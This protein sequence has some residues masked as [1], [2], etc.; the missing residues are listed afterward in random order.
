MD[1]KKALE[2]LNAIDAKDLKKID[3]SKLKEYNIERIKQDLST[4]PKLLIN[5][6]LLLM[7]VICI[8]S[9]FH[10]YRSGSAKI[11]KEMDELNQKNEIMQATK[12]QEVDYKTFMDNLPEIIPNNQLIGRISEI[13]ESSRVNILSF[14]PMNTEESEYATQHNV[15]LIVEA[16]TYGDI[17]NFIDT[18]ENSGKT[19]KI[20]QLVIKSKL[21]L[22]EVGLFE[23]GDEVAIDMVIEIVS[24]TL[25]NV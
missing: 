14:S 2:K 22:A 4:K 18:L 15:N 1:I 8:L 6:I 24:V 12:T 7:T 20:K 10:F 19:L 13:A 16:K 17:L 3:F 9:S 5:G 21:T 23:G 25:K 11:K